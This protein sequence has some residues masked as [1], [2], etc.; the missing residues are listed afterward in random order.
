MNEEKRYFFHTADNK[1]MDLSEMTKT[2]NFEN[3]LGSV[4][5]YH[6]CG[7]T[8]EVYERRLFSSKKQLLKDAISKVETKIATNRENLKSLSTMTNILDYERKN[9]KQMLADLEKKG[10]VE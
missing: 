8:G 9:Y 10:G 7:V 2:I 3:Y 6:G 5:A 4:I 1:I